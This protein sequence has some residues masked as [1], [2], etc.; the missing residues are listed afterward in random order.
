MKLIEVA[1]PLEAISSAIRAK[2]LQPARMEVA[3]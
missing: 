3:D 1:A 2:S